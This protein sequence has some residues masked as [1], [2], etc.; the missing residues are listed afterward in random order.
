MNIAVKNLLTS[1]IAFY[2]VQLL[3][4]L[5]PLLVLPFLSRNL[6]IDGFGKIM[7]FNS[8]CGIAYIIND[9]GF[10]L[11]ATHSISTNRNNNTILNNII[12]SIFILKIPLFILSS[13]SLILYLN[14]FS[15]I[16]YD[17]FAILCLLGV[18]LFQSLQPLWVFQGLE[19]M[20]KI[21]IFFVIPKIGYI[22]YVLLFINDDS[23]LNKIYF[24]LFICMFLNFIF[25]YF[26]MKKIGIKL[27]LPSLLV[28]ISTFKDSSS[29]FLSRAAVSIY[30]TVSSI[31]IGNYAGLTQLALYS[32]A[33]KIYQGLQSITG[34]ISQAIFPYLSFNKNRALIINLTL[35]T[36]PILGL[37]SIFTFIFSEDIISIIFGS[38]YIDSAFILRMFSIIMI[39]NYIGVNFGYPAFA[40]IDRIK[41]VNI[42]V[43]TGALIQT[44][45]LIILL[46]NE[47]ISAINIAYS[48]L[49][50]EL[51]VAIIRVFTFF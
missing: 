23:D 35:Y 1:S 43:I 8:L 2:I 51:S 27:I 28:L 19:I 33:E 12:S 7:L 3:N 20:K 22:F 14:Y 36:L 17:L 21:I 47:E 34:P 24:S 10:G 38:K 31:I 4:I 16:Q 50:T 30:T 5:S 26:S 41:I 32:C 49:F 15:N 13:I 37:I 11:S 45:L 48:V 29:F 42:T 6:S 44:L 9:F 25:L 40:T 46:I 39:I 18:S